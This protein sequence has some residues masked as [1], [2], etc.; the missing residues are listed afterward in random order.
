MKKKTDNSFTDTKIKGIYC[1][2]DIKRVAQRKKN[3]IR[4]IKKV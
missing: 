2:F 3:V 1:E 4:K